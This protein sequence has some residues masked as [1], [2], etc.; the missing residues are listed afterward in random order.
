MADMDELK[1]QV[2]LLL[3]QGW[4]DLASIQ[5]HADISDGDMSEIVQWLVDEEF[6]ITHTI[7]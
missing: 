1:H 4:T 5:E 7:H 6:I 2:I 3:A